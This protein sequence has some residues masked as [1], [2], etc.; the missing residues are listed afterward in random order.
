MKKDIKKEVDEATKALNQD[1]PFADVN[2]AAAD[3]PA[4]VVKDL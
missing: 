3:M 4:E 2:P 1:A